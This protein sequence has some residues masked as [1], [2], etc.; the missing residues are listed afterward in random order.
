M[1]TLEKLKIKRSS[2]IYIYVSGLIT[3]LILVILFKIDSLA[4]FGNKSLAWMD[5]N[6]QYLDF[7]SYFHDVLHGN[8]D[9]FYT[10]G[11]TLGGRNIAV[12]SYYLSSPFCLLLFFIDPIHFHTFFDLIVAIKLALASFFMAAFLHKR[13]NS[14]ITSSKQAFIIAMLSLCYGI[15]QYTIAQASN[16]MWLDGV[17]LLPL[18][19]LSI[20]ELVYFKCI[21]KLSIIIFISIVFNWYTAGINCIFS[22]IIFCI[23]CIIFQLYNTKNLKYYIKL[24]FCYIYSP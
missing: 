24:L 11:K 16:I 22:F 21:W 17:Y 20:Y 6:I 13:F 14:N 18:T 1:Q 7:Y 12:F 23:E 5:A 2:K 3:F 4:P 8:N 15:N 19:M 9:I 10:F